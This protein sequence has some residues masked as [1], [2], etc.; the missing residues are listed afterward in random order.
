MAKSEFAVSHRWTSDYRSPSRWVLS[1][2]RDYKLI[3]VVVLIGAAGNAALAVALPIFTGVAFDAIVSDSPD[4]TKLLWVSILLV[5]TQTVRT[6]LQLGRN[7]GSEVLGQRLERDSR[8]ELYASLLGKSMGFHDLHATGDIMARATNDVRELALMMAPGLN[9]VVGS[10]NFLIMPLIVV[11][12]IDPQLLLTPVLF[13]IGYFFSMRWYLKSLQPVTKA[14]RE[15]FGRL[16][17]GLTESVEGIETVKGAAQEVYEV[18]RFEINARR[19]RDAFVDQGRVEARFLPLLLLGIAQGLAFGH[20]L[21][22]YSRGE[23][24]VGD[25]VAYMGIISLLGFPVFVSL[26]SYSQVS[27]GLSS[28]RRIMELITSKADLDQNDLGFQGKM[29]GAFRFD[30]VSFN[31]SVVGREVADEGPQVSQAALEEVS[32]DVEAGQTLALVGQTGSGK[33][34]VAKLINRIYDVNQGCVTV[35]GVDVRDWNL[36][37]LRQQISIIEQDVFLF[38]R[39]IAENIAFGKPGATPSEI[40]DAARSAQAHD[41]IMGFPEQYETVVGERGTMLSGGQRQRLA[42]A[43]AF[44][45][46]PAILILDDSTSAIDSATEDQIQQA[47]EAATE[48]RTTILITH[49]LSQIRWA[50]KI[51]VLRRGRVAAMGTH[52]E[53]L[54]Q[55]QAYR[56]IFARF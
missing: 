43:R 42:L 39:T 14:V 36:A 22:L 3:I 10:A 29:S 4:V 25:V 55:S 46:D 20:A 56:D 18:T 47:I 12:S 50:D 44:L 5:I 30:D 6:V 37:T 19:L 28:A 21:L 1:H 24:T 31:Y 9:L 38:S 11:P 8:V 7:F 35:D 32:F 17:A 16:N 54:E 15:N 23:V 41:F 27:S 45:T 34:T 33:S 49:R 26:F 13:I 2:L 40:E 51:V 52:E 53:L 48:G